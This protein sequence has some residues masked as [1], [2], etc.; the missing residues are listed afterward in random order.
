[1]RWVRSVN[2]AWLRS[3][4]I[5][6]DTT[7]NPCRWVRSVNRAWLR[8]ADINTDTTRKPCRWVRSVVA[9]KGRVRSDHGP[10]SFVRPAEFVRTTARVRS[11]GRR[12]SFGPLPEFV[13]ADD[14]VRSDSRRSSFAPRVEF[15]RTAGGVRSD[16]RRSSFA[17][18]AGFGPH[19]LQRI[20]FVRACFEFVRAN[21]SEADHYDAII[22]IVRFHIIP[23]IRIASEPP[24]TDFVR[25]L[26][27]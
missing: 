15:V 11:C 27:L 10:S 19:L 1:M 12:S 16:G 2:R 6:T 8:S 22:T 4:D 17:P 25:A 20:E 14:G 24:R 3:A 7:R 9:P 5:N 26:I 23:D 13:R 21:R 18:R